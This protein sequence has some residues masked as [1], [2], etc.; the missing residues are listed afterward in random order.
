MI[1]NL[2]NGLVRL[3]CRVDLLSV[4]DKAPHL[5]SLDPAVTFV[6]LRA[7][8]ALSAV[9]PL[10]R[11]LR[12]AR[13]LGLLAAKDRANLAAVIAKGIARVETRVVT[14]LG[15]TITA[16]I[17][18]RDPF[19]RFFWR[20]PPRLTYRLANAVVAVSNG[21]ARDLSA[22][23][24]IS[25]SSIDVIP[26]P[27]ITPDFF[28]RA[29]M[30]PGHPWFEARVD[31]RTTPVIFGM[32][33][34][35]RQKDFPTLVRA[36]GIVR[37]K[38]PCRLVIFGEGRDR[39]KL[40][41]MVSDLG[42]SRDVCLPGFVSN[43]YPCLSRASLFV[44]SSAWEGSPNALTEALALGIPVVSTDCPSGPREILADGKYG[45]LVP[46]G[47]HEAMAEAML[48]TLEAPP[49]TAF[50]QE[51]ARAYTQEEASRRYLELLIRP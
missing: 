49:E 10:S 35:T 36:F 44:L 40:E 19:C 12:K 43:P 26:N 20:L 5:A 22:V 8:H 48:R 21:V 13:P 23:A 18:H 9:Y 41:T 25:E 14:R 28:D 16:S 1:V 33:R 30:P 47:D 37:E 42:L 34:L 31:V 6:K 39:A 7:S 11:Y 3:G 2:C 4:K 50:L 15:T 24:G 32:G 29:A 45:P 51:A 17:R 46:V 27:V 38:R